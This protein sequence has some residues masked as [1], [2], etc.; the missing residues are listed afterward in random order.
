VRRRD[1]WEAKSMGVWVE[2]S[3]A[4]GRHADRVLTEQTGIFGICVERKETEC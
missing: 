3:S 4:D 2:M 1:R